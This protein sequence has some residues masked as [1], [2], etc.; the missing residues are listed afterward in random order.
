V[1]VQHQLE[2]PIAVEVDRLTERKV[3]ERGAIAG[4]WSRPVLNTRESRPGHL[5]SGVMRDA[6]GSG[7]DDLGKLRESLAG[8]AFHQH[9]HELA[10]GR[11]VEVLMYLADDLDDPCSRYVGEPGCQ[12]VRDVGEDCD[13]VD[14]HRTRRG[15][16]GLGGDGHDS[17]CRDQAGPA[18]G[19]VGDLRGV[20]GAHTEKGSTAPSPARRVARRSA[21]HAT[22]SGHGDQC[23]YPG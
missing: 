11:I 2:E 21:S 20:A 3:A 23:V 1:V 7:R 6:G 17:G 14:Q 9:R 19:G 16:N 22:L 8:L 15:K 4:G 13:L 18:S 12:A 5:R 10:N